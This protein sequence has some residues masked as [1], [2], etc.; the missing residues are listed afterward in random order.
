MT[1]GVPCVLAS[2][3]TVFSSTALVSVR[4][5]KILELPEIGAIELRAVE[6]VEDVG[7]ALQRIPVRRDRDELSQVRLADLEDVAVGQVIRDAEAPTR[8]LDHPPAGGDDRDGHLHGGGVLMGD[9]TTG[10]LDI[11]VRAAPPRII[12]MPHDEGAK[13][14][15]YADNL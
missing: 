15:G 8:V 9:Q 10:L 3:S 6:A 5:Q 7:I 4:D 1:I 2:R 14:V 13:D 11:E 12:R